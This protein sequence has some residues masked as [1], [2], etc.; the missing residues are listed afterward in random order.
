MNKIK[1]LRICNWSLLIITIVM[2][3]SSIQLEATH[4]SNILFVWLHVTLGI[5]S[6]GLIVWHLQLHFKWKSW[7]KRLPALK[8]SLTKWLTAIVFL[9]F[10][11]GIVALFHWLTKYQHSPIGALHGKLGFAFIALGIAHSIKHIKF[12]K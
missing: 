6:L 8:S 9:A 3:A 1:K 2:L 4:S 7:H 5:G 11:S 12:F 10:S